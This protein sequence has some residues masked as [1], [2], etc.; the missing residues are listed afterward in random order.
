VFYCHQNRSKYIMKL[1]DNEIRDVVKYLEDG[2]PLPDKYRFMLFDDKREVELIWNGK[3]SDVTNTVLPFQTIELIDEPRDEEAMKNQRELFDFSGR[4]IAD[5]TNKL[6]WGDNKLILS[7]LKNGP[8]RQEIEE[9]GGI[10]LIYIDPP[11][12]AGIDYSINVNIGDDNQPLVKQ[13][14]ALEEFA[15]RNTWGNG[16]NTFLSMLYER[17][18]LMKGLLSSDGKIFVRIDHHWG[19]YVKAALDEVFGKDTFQS[20]ILVNRTRK[21]VTEQG[22][23]SL[24]T[25]TDSVF[26]YFNDDAKYS[27]ISKKLDEERAGYW[28][29][30]DDS[31]GERRP[32]ER[33]IFGKVF[34]APPGKHFKFSQDNIE[35][36][37]AEGTLRENTSTGKLQYWVK[38][39]N[40]IPLDTNWTDIPGYSFTTGYPTE[41]SEKLLERIIDIS[42]REGDIVA[43]FFNGSGT[44]IAV[45][46]KM[47]RKWIGTDLGK[48][49]IHTTRKRMIGVQRSLKASGKKLS[50]F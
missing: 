34:Q 1:T 15:Y 32:R 38:P 24:P 41:N 39:K 3:N 42:T 23:L 20:E 7:S 49:S 11:F 18:K 2:K 40:T 12:S 50:C 46:E 45:A 43:D 14:T 22:K 17:F 6:I 47:G 37:A 27:H 25:A 36:M 33:H 31:A 29:A 30:A 21:N 44:T 4:Q 48:F 16:G 9:Q 26:V 10:K 19:H 35:K 13:P 8:L 5:W 28:R